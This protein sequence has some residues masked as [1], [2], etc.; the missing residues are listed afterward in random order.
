MFATDAEALLVA[1]TVPA[2]ST[3]RTSNVCLPF[4]TEFDDQKPGV[5]PNGMFC[6]VSTT[7]PSTRKRIDPGSS[8]V[9]SPFE[10]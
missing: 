3:A 9:L 8:G 10:S 4:P 1:T 7:L 2:P 5:S 6:S